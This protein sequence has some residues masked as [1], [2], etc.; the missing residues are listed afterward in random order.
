MPDEG[1]SDLEYN[2]VASI[3]HYRVYRLIPAGNIVATQI[4]SMRPRSPAKPLTLSRLVQ[5]YIRE[6]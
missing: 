4:Q 2:L 6:C 1:H 5:S 3:V